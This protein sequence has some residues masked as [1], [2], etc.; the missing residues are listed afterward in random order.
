MKKVTLLLLILS[1]VPC[2]GQETQNPSVQE[3]SQLHN[4]IM[5]SLERYASMSDEEKDKLNTSCLLA[6][7]LYSYLVAKEDIVVSDSINPK[8]L[9]GKIEGKQILEKLQIIGGLIKKKEEEFE[10]NLKKLKPSE[11]DGE[12]DKATQRITELKAEIVAECAVVEELLETIKK[13]GS[14]AKSEINEL[15][16]SSCTEFKKLEK[17]EKSDSQKTTEAIDSF[18]DQDIAR[19]ILN[20]KTT[21][22]IREK[23]EKKEGDAKEIR[24]YRKE[25]RKYKYDGKEIQFKNAVLIFFNNKATTIHVEA[26]IGDKTIDLVNG[27]YS[28]PI[29]AFLFYRNVSQLIKYKYHLVGEIEEGIKIKVPVTEIFDYKSIIKGKSGNFGYS[30]ANQ[31]VI[32]S[33]DDEN[34]GVGSFVVKQRRFLDFFN[35]VVYSDLMGF[36][37]E[38]SNSALNAQ[39]SLLKPLNLGSWERVSAFRQFRI[40]SNIALSNSFEDENRFIGFT[41]DEQVPHFDLLRKNNLNA[42][43]STDLISIEA[44]GWFSVIS[45]GYNLG[46]YRTGFRYTNTESS[47]EDEIT[48]GQLLSISHGPYVGFEFRPQDNFGADLMLSLEKFSLNDRL[49]LNSRDFRDDIVTDIKDNDFLLNHNIINF[50][51]SFYWLTSPG[52]SNG[53][54]YA[55][56]GVAYH[57]PTDAIFPQFFVGYATNLTSFVNRFK[58]K[59]V[60]EQVK[61]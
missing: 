11:K 32:L 57:T 46:F 15:D 35:A 40:I 17:E 1:I 27:D 50:S 60:P 29:R 2:F 20:K 39:A 48:N 19:I 45:F 25:I 58:Q 4:E 53:G 14:V 59:E 6:T 52:K 3:L 12:F 28:I 61:E 44:K 38:N 51:S 31:K 41:D 43:M 24:K 36:N 7:S 10:N 47:D 37:T 42:V 21:L 9:C 18:G 56:L 23:P 22:P 54:V 26:S 8:E 16:L 30:V 5:T 34:D 55:R 13:N 33:H 49:T